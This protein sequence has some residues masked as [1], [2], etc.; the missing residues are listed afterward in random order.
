MEDGNIESGP[1]SRPEWE[2]LEEWLRGQ[3]QGLIQE[4]LEQ[5]VTEFLGRA[6]SIRRSE[7]DNDAGYRNGYA[8][9]RRLTL[10]SG[11][12]RIRRPRIRDTEERFESRLLPLF[13]HRTREVADLIPELYL[14]GLSEG[15]FDLALRGLLGE[16][17]PISASTVARLKDKWNAELA[18]WRAR[19]L[20][21]LEVVYMWVDGV[22]V[23]A[24]LE[25]EKAA[26]LV[27]MAALSDGRKV[28]VVSAAPGYRESTQS[29][30]DVLRD[31]KRRG[32]SCPR[33]VV[34]DGHL[35]IW[36]ALRNVY[37]QAAEQRCWNHKV[38]NVLDRLPK[39][40][41]EEAKLL[42]RRIPYAPSRTEAERLRTAFTRWC[43]DR[44]Y[45]AAAEA[46]ERDWDRMI[47]FYDFPK[48]HWQHLRT[49]NPVESPF[50]ALRLRTDA[51][52][53]YKR[54][55]RAIAV[56]WKMLMV[57]EGRFRRLKAPELIEDVYLGAQYADGIAIE[58]TAEMVA[59]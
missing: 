54:V 27:V 1:A 17:A 19:P 24:G 12:I 50:A 51:A 14:H 59:A 28:V 25:R 58:S 45:E 15:D 37:R 40:R 55:D 3:M 33:L 26:I 56:I 21:D 43:R 23:K 6:R 39:R 48:E 16:E 20:D 8:P 29:W 18:E 10:S 46:L 22:Y 38:M 4:L 57:A 34:G 11:T 49:T 52:K 13:V 42:L 44:S 2:H 36:G 31:I 35:G 5:E 9:P 53:R 47:T 41:Q 32:L 7:S 30:S